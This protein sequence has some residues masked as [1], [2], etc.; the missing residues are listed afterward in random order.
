MDQSVRGARLP[1][2]ADDA[3]RRRGILEVGF[4]Q[5]Y[6]SEDGG[7]AIAKEHDARRERCLTCRAA[8][9]GLCGQLHGAERAAYNAMATP[10]RYETGQILCEEGAPSLR[11]FS[12]TQGMAGRFKSLPDGRRIITGF[13]FEGDLIG[14]ASRSAYACTVEAVTPLGA[15]VFRRDQFERF[16]EEHPEAYREVFDLAAR[17]LCAAQEQLLLLGRKSARERVASFILHLADAAAL[18]HRAT[19]PVELPMSRSAIAD[20]LGLTIETVSRTLSGLVRSGAIEL[21][22]VSLIRIRSRS[23]LQHIANGD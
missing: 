12:I 11:L 15:C 4:M 20:Y 13:L 14:L 3:S 9:F 10:A 8:E 1:K 5:L 19:N 22:Q 21:E 23:G 17:E 7:G 2:L 18:R 16:L 6:R